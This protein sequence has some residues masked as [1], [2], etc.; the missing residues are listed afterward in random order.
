M[1]SQIDEKQVR[2]KAKQLLSDGT[3]KQETYEQ[4]VDKFAGRETLAKIVK[5]IPSQKAWE[6]YG[7]WNHVLSALMILLLLMMMLAN[8]TLGTFIWYGLPTLAILMRKTRFYFWIAILAGLGTVT[9]VAV[10]LSSADSIQIDGIIRISIFFVLLF[11]AAFLAIWL[12]KKLTPEPI[13]KR[14]F[15][16]NKYGEKRSRIL[17]KFAEKA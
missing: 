7:V 4:L 6:K 1:A 13:E 15:Y 3:T 12:P 10:T 11:P 16:E 2:K 8:P 14:E 5:R 17:F 9:I